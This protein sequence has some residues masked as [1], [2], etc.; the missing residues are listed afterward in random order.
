VDLGDGGPDAG[1]GAIR[2]STQEVADALAGYAE[3]GISHL[4]AHVFPR[5]PDAIA[6]F[7]EAVTLT[8]A[9]LGA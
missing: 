8:K 5:T 4:I 9:R 6:R 1:E 3:L 7:A 2:G